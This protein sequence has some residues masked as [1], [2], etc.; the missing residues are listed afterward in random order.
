MM[1]NKWIVIFFVFFAGPVFAE[2]HPRESILY[3]LNWEKHADNASISTE[4]FYS[5]AL[6]ESG[7]YIDNKFKPYPWA[8]GVGRETSIGQMK[9][10]SLY[11]RNIEEA[12]IT[13]KAL[14]DAGH[15]NLGVGMM[16][17]SIMYHADK[18]DSLYDLLEP[19]INMSIS[20]AIIKNCR[21]RYIT[22]SKVLSCYRSGKPNTK[23]GVAYALEAL[24]FK[25][26]F[27][28]TFVTSLMPTPDYAVGE[29]NIMLLSSVW[30]NIDN[31]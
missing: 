8:I 16:Q 28:S 26:K 20:S 10:E 19:S 25:D 11:P 6:K 7:K 1:L 29:L 13:L 9:H 21:R 30:D 12:R 23:R 15:K 3:N 31:K 5:I 24:D 18:V 17:V 22:E 27:A 2:D 14:L 4:L